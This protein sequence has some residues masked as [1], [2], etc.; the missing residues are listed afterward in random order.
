MNLKVALE[1]QTGRLSYFPNQPELIAIQRYEQAFEISRRPIP[2][3]PSRNLP[4]CDRLRHRGENCGGRS[5]Q[6]SEGRDQSR[7]FYD[8]S[9]C[10]GSRLHNQQ[11]QRQRYRI[12]RAITISHN[13]GD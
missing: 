6:G 13:T 2:W 4:L 10:Q 8:Q 7:R 5:C 12:G 3:T 9:R 1:E 11:R